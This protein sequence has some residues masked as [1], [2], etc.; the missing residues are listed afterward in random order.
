MDRQDRPA[1]LFRLRPAISAWLF[2][3]L[4]LA[5]CGMLIAVPLGTGTSSLR[6]LTE[7]LLYVVLASA[8]NLLSGY[9]GMVSVG[10]QAYVGLGAYAFHTGL[11]VLHLPLAVAMVMAGLVSGLVAVLFAPLLFRLEGA[12]FAI[13]TWVTAEICLLLVANTDALG[14]G[15]GLSLPVPVALAIAAT[16]FG[17]AAVNY[18]LALGLALATLGFI[19]LLLRSTWGLG[20]MAVRDCPRAA[21]SIGVPARALKL[22]IF[23]A[24]AVIAGI[25]GCL[26]LLIKTR[27][28]PDSAFSQLDWTAYVIFIVVIGG[29]GRLI[30]PVLGVLLFFLLRRTLGDIGPLYPVLLGTLAIG[31]VLFSGT[32]LAGL[33]ARFCKG[34]TVVRRQRGGSGNSRTSH[35]EGGPKDA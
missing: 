10:Q 34:E 18:Y 6:L 31:M 13:G 33:A 17:R 25:A 21:E 23:I 9:G 22:L 28:T 30:G 19:F 4:L 7:V 14:A 5:A 16:S 11:V 20:I 8:W 35:D 3:L 32:G 24:A 1:D 2:P 29:K 15:A 26:I 12:Y 27:I